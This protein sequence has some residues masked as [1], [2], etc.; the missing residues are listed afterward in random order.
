MAMKTPTTQQ[1][2][3]PAPEQTNALAT[4]QSFMPAIIGGANSVQVTSPDSRLPTVKI[5]NPIEIDPSRGLTPA[6]SYGLVMMEGESVKPLPIGATI[7]VLAARDAARQLVVEINGAKVKHDG[8]KEHQKLDASY[9]RCYKGLGQF[10]KSDAQYQAALRD[11]ANWQTGS[12]Y[13]VAVLM[14]DNSCAI[15]ELPAFKTQ[16]SYWFRPLSQSILSP[17][18]LGC[19]LLIDNH[20]VN[21]K[22]S[23]ND[24]QK[25]YCDP[26]KFV[27]YEIVELTTDQLKAVMGAAEAKK[28]DIN[29]WFER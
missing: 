12:T 23:K 3:T 1:P 19:R 5:V 11:K 8:S 7:T 13:L 10:T 27:Q 9:D 26:S 16:A 2:Q 28:T 4:V 22:A 6:M 21:V 20:A 15:A 18:K 24:S 29:S 14:P 17:N 25:K